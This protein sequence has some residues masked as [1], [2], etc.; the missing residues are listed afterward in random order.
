MTLC[1]IRWSCI[2]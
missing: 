1:E 2:R